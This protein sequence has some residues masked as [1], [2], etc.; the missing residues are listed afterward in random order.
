M[1]KK[2]IANKTQPVSEKTTKRAAAKK[3]EQSPPQEAV[4]TAKAAAADDARKPEGSPGQGAAA[5]SESGPRRTLTAGVPQCTIRICTPIHPEFDNT[6]TN[7]I[8]TGRVV[9]ADAVVIVY[10][11]QGAP[12]NDI[13]S[14]QQVT[15]TSMTFSASL[16]WSTGS[17]ANGDFVIRARVVPTLSSM[18]AAADELEYVAIDPNALRKRP[19]A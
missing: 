2:K 17:L 7:V 9:P 12:P 13:V 19:R 11:V 5:A 10:V 14:S 18:C 15:A 3:A 8:V 6:Q 4:K 16:T 1:A